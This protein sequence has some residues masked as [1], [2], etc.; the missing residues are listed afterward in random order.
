MSFFKTRKVSYLIPVLSAKVDGRMTIPESGK[1][2]PCPF[3]FVQTEDQNPVKVS[4]AE[5]MPSGAGDSMRTSLW[6]AVMTASLAL[7]RDLV[8]VRISVETSGYVD[9]PSAGGMFCL[10]V[11]SALD[12]SGRIVGRRFFD[13]NGREIPMPGQMNNESDASAPSQEC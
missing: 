13:L 12:A 5:D 6:L 3:S 2:I 1:V 7:N 4:I 8:G 11:M 10:A 9:G